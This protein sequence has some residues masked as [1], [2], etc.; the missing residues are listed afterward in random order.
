MEQDSNLAILQFG[1]KTL[2]RDHER[3]L[4]SLEI[5]KHR[6]DLLNEKYNQLASEIRNLHHSVIMNQ[7]GFFAIED[8]LSSLN[9]PTNGTLVWKITNLAARMIEA[10]Q[11][12]FPSFYSAPFY[13]SPYGYKLCAR[14]YLNGDGAGRNTHLS[15]FITVMQGEYDALLLWPFRQQITIQLLSQSTTQFAHHKETFKPDPNSTSF[16]RP[17][18]TMNVSSGLPQFIS[19]QKLLSSENNFVKDDAIF[20]KF[21]IEQ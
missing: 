7:V 21:D 2:L 19:L 1:F 16:S 9:P 13:T 3:L 18:T 15:V 20:L 6:I 10:R 14:I 4:S 12:R 17:K 8:N 11:N 5:M